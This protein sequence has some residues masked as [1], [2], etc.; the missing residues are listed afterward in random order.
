MS[1][2]KFQ[3]TVD[4]KK[5]AEVY[6]V[7]G[8]EWG[9]PFSAEEYGRHQANTLVRW[10]LSGR[11]GRGFFLECKS[12][13][14]AASCIITQHK[15]FY[16]EP[17]RGAIAGVPDPSAFGVNNITGLRIEHVFTKKEHRGKGLMG[18]L[19]R[20]AIDYTED[21][22]I[23]KELAKSSDKK[24]GLKLMVTTDGK[25]DKTLANYY[26]SKKYFWYLYSAI[27]DSYKKFGF[28]SY[29]LD[30]YQV[31]F[32]LAY[33]DTY[34]LVEKALMTEAEHVDVGKKI[35]FLEGSKK[36]DRDL[37]ESIFQGRELDL[38]TD[39]S[40]G[41]FHS[42]LAGGQRS[43]SS[44]TNIATALS[45]IK[46]G[47]ANELSAISEKLEQTQIDDLPNETIRRKLSVHSFGVPRMGIKPEFSNIQRYYGEEEAIAEKAGDA[48]NDKF[49]KVKGAILTN[50]L[51][52]KSYYILWATIMHKQFVIMGMGELKL[53][54]FGAVSDPSGFVNPLSRRRGSAFTELNDMGAFNLQDMALLLN[55]AVFVAK[56]RNGLNPGVLVTINDLPNT[57]PTP[58]LH[59]FFLGNLDKPAKPTKSFTEDEGGS[60]HKRV[61]YIKDFGPQ[62]LILPLLKRFGNDSSEFEIDWTGNGLM[63]WG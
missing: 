56:R 55:T 11:A 60:E 2:Y 22:I 50:E 52:Q 25:V 20:K 33:T 18:R 16:K 34:K 62:N 15:G 8:T 14:I 7:S 47:S 44:L 36:L 51:Q 1:D 49:S 39:L 21:E 24:D 23:K 38:L 30:G 27:G 53:D 13:E 45:T 43:S 32:S 29:P 48:E 19:V 6:A 12:G 59:D 28:K 37:I 42:E 46:L 35:R 31:P 4:P 40:K 5:L 63:T 61:A 41:T 9:A 54:L 17:E 3:T 58:V 57:V 10:I 26:L